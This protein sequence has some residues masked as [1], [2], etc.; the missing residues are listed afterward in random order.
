M[1]LKYKIFPLYGAALT[2]SIVTVFFSMLHVMKQNCL[3]Q[4]K[5][6]ISELLSTT[7]E[8]VLDEL[9]KNNDASILKRLETLKTKTSARITLID[10][11]GKVIFD[12][13]ANTEDMLRHND[14]PEVISAIEKGFGDSYR[15]STTLKKYF[16]Y[17]A[18]PIQT[19]NGETLVLRTSR[20]EDIIFACLNDH[21]GDMLFCC[22]LALAIGLLMI[23]MISKKINAPLL[24]IR[25]QVANFAKGDFSRTIHP[26]GI[27]EID[28]MSEHIDKMAVEMKESLQKTGKSHKEMN[29]I[30]SSMREG[31]IA[32]DA[33]G[34]VILANRSARDLFNINDKNAS[35][36]RFFHELIRNT[37]TQR[38]IEGILKTQNDLDDEIQV[39]GIKKT[40]LQIRGAPLLSPDR[41]TI[42]ALVVF[43][44]ISKLKRLENMRRDFV[45]NV[46][47]EIRTPLTAIIGAVETL[48]E[49]ELKSKDRKKMLDILAKHSQRLNALVEDILSLSKIEQGADELDFK[50]CQISEL[51]EYAIDAC[52]E[53]AESKAIKIESDCQCFEWRID[54]GL[55]QQA[56]I[57]LIDNAIKY[58]DSGGSIEVKVKKMD[59]GFTISIS[60][61]GC[62]ISTEH[63]PRIFERFYRVDKSRS[64]DLG[65]TGL[66][67]AIV[68]YVVNAHD[69]EVSVKS[70]L[71]KGSTF[72]IEIKDK[73]SQ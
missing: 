65:G 49:N 27:H 69:G 3:S 14:R 70:S 20:S 72:T 6:T 18:I 38:L 44:D 37:E 51:V 7:K 4:T 63:I 30:L 39:F 62:G 29:A 58:S 73:N 45:A 28:R 13:D 55:F 57:N 71:G 31:V 66:G 25:N 32:V 35:D 68:K 1:T 34:R 17:C 15:F 26:C 16:L 53:K 61:T 8:I 21:M 46:S 60:D 2:V 33:E 40:H 10:P 23:L 22:L 50:E 43:N 5:S 19:E 36:R 9:K 56:I 42:G 67:L 41:K 52:K 24:D 64:R 12:S 48:F 54:P 47:H 59:H 11:S